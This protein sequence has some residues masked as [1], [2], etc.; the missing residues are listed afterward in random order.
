L[1]S[2][3]FVVHKPVEENDNTQYAWIKTDG[4]AYF[5]GNVTVG[6][7][8]ANAQWDTKFA[9]VT[10]ELSETK[11]LV[12]KSNETIAKLNAENVILK[13]KLTLFE[14]QI[15]QL[16]A[17]QNVEKIAHKTRVKLIK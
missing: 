1:D 6:G 3:A 9:N 2:K 5:A 13:E 17:M 10:K 16:L 11:E 8:L 12:A 4:S 7:E 14:Q 15:E